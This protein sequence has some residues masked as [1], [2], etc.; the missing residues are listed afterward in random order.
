MFN[1][2][3]RQTATCAILKKQITTAFES[4]YEIR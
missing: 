3:N 4:E 1:A 2:V